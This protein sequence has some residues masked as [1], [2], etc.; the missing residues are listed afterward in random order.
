ML[1]CIAYVTGQNTPLSR[2]LPRGTIYVPSTANSIDLF[3]SVLDDNL[4]SN[5]LT[6]NKVK[7]SKN[8]LSFSFQPERSLEVMSAPISGT[9]FYPS[10]NI[11]FFH[12]YTLDM[13]AYESGDVVFIKIYL[14]DD[15]N[16]VTEIPTNGSDYQIIKHFS[17][18][19]I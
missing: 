16:S 11:D 6:Y 19:V 15:V 17:F 9:G 4:I 18:T 2:E 10:N 12:K 3:F 8:L 13:S 14:Q 5:E 1:G 7:F